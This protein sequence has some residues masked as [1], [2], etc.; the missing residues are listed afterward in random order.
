MS[1]E[2]AVISTHVRHGRPRRS[3]QRRATVMTPSIPISVHATRCA[4]DSTAS[5]GAS[6][7]QNAGERPH[8]VYATSA[9]A[10]PR[11]APDVGAA[12]SGAVSGAALLL[13]LGLRHDRP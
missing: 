11:P 7:G 2:P 10:A 4:T 13:V 6:S 8:S 3:D 9:G 1:A 12:T 5:A